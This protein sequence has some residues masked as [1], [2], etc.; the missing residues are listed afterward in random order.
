MRQYIILASGG[1]VGDE[2][3]LQDL[4]FISKLVLSKNF[5]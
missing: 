4:I 1:D 2:E 3:N 5:A